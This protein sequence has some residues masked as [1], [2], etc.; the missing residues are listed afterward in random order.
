MYNLAF[1]AQQCNFYLRC[2]HK[3]GVIAAPSTLV[4][5][6]K[7]INYSFINSL[8]LILKKDGNVVMNTDADRV[9]ENIPPSHGVAYLKTF[10]V[11][12]D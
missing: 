12:R 9:L 4:Q 8:N 2:V 1:N 11:R 6:E 5:G 10:I 7:S 3:H